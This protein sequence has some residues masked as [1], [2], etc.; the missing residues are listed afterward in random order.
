MNDFLQ[1][2]TS[3]DGRLNRQRFWLGIVGL[4]IAYIVVGFIVGWFFGVNPMAML[5]SAISTNGDP[6]VLAKLAM[7][8]TRASG[9]SSLITLIILAIPGMA[10]WI[11]RSHD[12]DQGP[13]LIYALYALLALQYLLQG[14]GLT[15]T[16]VELGETQVPTMS[17][18]GW[19]LSAITAILGLY[20]LIT[21]G[22]LKGTE[23]PNQYGPDPLGATGGDMGA[24][25]GGDMGG[26]DTG[27]SDAS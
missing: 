23:G 2:Y 21:L 19:I 9:W 22:F 3:F 4:I 1:L 17:M 10:L 7:D 20:L 26:G 24:S 16:M 12:R 25:G 27:G 6:D 8:A 18:I 15:M 14:L 11:K 5:Q 13:N